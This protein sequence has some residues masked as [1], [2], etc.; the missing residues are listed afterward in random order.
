MAPAHVDD[1]LRL[2]AWCGLGI[3]TIY[4]C[5][6]A[7]ALRWSHRR[8]TRVI[9]YD[10]PQNIS[11]A[12][13]CYL[14]ERGATEKP[15]VVALASMAAKGIVQIERGPEDYLITKLK[16][17]AT[18]EPE[19]DAI[20]NLL[21]RSGPAIL[22]SRIFPSL[23]E[24]A[25]R[26]L[27]SAVQSAVEPELIS[28]HFAWL[29]PGITLSLWS[30]PAAVYPDFGKIWNESTGRLVILPV[31]CAVVIFLAILKTAP[32][33]LYK[34]KSRMPGHAPHPLPFTK[35]D[36][37][38]VSLSLM[39]AGCTCA[40][41]FFTSW[42]LALQLT[43]FLVANTIAAVA[44]HAP[45]AD[46]RRL[47]EQIDDYREFLMDV[48][49]D[50]ANR[51]SPPLGASPSVDKNWPWALALGIEHAWGEQFAAAVLN[52]VGVPAAVDTIEQNLGDEPGRDLDIMDP[53]LSK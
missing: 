32:A 27:R 2:V 28:S 26:D 46:G 47:L 37:K 25:A 14:R 52:R 44:F 31:A 34:I 12:V 17:E 41:A 53:G 9:R 38:V 48:D 13:A 3:V 22:L 49:A 35:S 16:H 45:T 5:A 19:E 21:F 30:L 33:T 40:I 36:L 10:P 50:R 1:Q 20:A 11:P 39:A 6:V 8:S 51:M 29:V 18:L 4:F 24:L 43:A 42:P 7:I 23:W 15:L